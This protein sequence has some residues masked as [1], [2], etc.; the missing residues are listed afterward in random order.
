VF[1]CFYFLFV[2]FGRSKSKDVDIY[3]KEPKIGERWGSAP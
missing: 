2:L 1:V 3:R